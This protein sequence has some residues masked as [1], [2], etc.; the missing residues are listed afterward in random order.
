MLEWLGSIIYHL[1]EHLEDML[2]IQVGR[3][4]QSF[5]LES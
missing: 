4:Y 1:V 2:M 5:N 3:V